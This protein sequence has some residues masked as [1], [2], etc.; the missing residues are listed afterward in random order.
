LAS[1]DYAL[2]AGQERIELLPEVRVFNGCAI[3]GA[4][5][6]LFPAF[7]PFGN[8]FL[9]ILGVGVQ[10]NAGTLLEGAQRMYNRAHFHA[11]VGG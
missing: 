1:N 7:Q 11:V 5:L 4:P 9:N 2:V 3:G 8:P 6:A 10:R